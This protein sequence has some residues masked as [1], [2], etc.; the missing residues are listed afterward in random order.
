MKLF[1][2]SGMSCASCVS[3]VENAVRKVKGVKSVE[4]NLL[5]SS[6]SVEFENEISVSEII[7]AVSKAGYEAKVK[8]SDINSEK[9]KNQKK[10][11]LFNFFDSETKKL[12]LRFCVSLILLFPLMYFAMS[13]EKSFISGIVQAVISFLIL[14]IN[15]KFFVSGIKS[16]FHLA[17]N[18]DTL[19]AMGSGVSFLFSIYNLLKQNYFNLY[20]DSA[21]MIVTLITIGKT[22]ESYSKGKTTDALNSLVKLAPK[23]AV[24]IKDEKEITVLISE[25]KPGDVVVVKSGESVPV[26]GIIINGSASFNESTLTGE[27]VP[28]DKGKDE[29]VFAAT[30][31]V[32]GN[33]FVRVEKTDDETAFSKIVQLVTSASASKAPVAKIADKVSAVFV[34]VVIL[35]SI[36]TFLCHFISDYIFY[37]GFSIPIFAEALSFAICVL[38]IS[39]PCS[40]GL[41]TPVSIMVANG[42]AAKRKILFKTAEALENVSKIEMCVFD[43]TGTVTNGV[44]VVKNIYFTEQNKENEKEILSLIYSLEKKSSHPLAEAICTY[45]EKQNIPL[46][47]TEEFTEKISFGISAVINGRSVKG[48][49]EKFVFPE[50]NLSVKIEDGETPLYFSVDDKTVLVITLLDV[51]KTTS[52]NAVLELKK[53]DIESVLLTGDNEKTA[54]IIASSVGIEKVFASATPEQKAG[55]IKK[56][57]EVNE[58]NNF[59]NSRKIRR[60]AMIGDGVN[61]APALKSAFAGF[62]IGSGT[63]VAVDSA[64]VVLVKN[65]LRDVVKAIKISRRTMT[66]IRQNLFWAFFYNAVCIPVAAGVFASGGIILKPVFGALAMSFSSIFVVMNAL[67]LNFMKLENKMKKTIRINGMMCEHCEAHVKKALEALGSSAVVSHKSGTAIVE[68]PDEIPH[69]VLAKAV[70]DAGYEVVEIS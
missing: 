69:E 48:G 46:L 8:E 1:D 47:Q 39:C 15:K 38:V 56:L 33:V 66:N 28:K 4:V 24:R 27:S 16:A 55:I 35:I 10:F 40:L 6:M 57:S 49:N 58:E 62:A 22:L 29:K 44:P 11:F 21:A 70:T 12:L 14:I 5:T 54:E 68:A 9:N 2:V 59:T 34:P 13:A 36:I 61:D 50:K 30:L 42:I 64:D 60:V 45:F 23:T 52:L 41:A 20:F 53:M 51:A 3:H 31:C 25:I 19:V 18:M 37:G 63:D 32:S 43:K 26:D 17:C 67:R 65:D 7:D